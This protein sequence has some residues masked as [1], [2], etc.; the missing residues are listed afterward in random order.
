M[1][2]LR[3]STGA[4]LTAL[5]RDGLRAHTGGSGVRRCGGACWPWITARADLAC[6]WAMV[7]GLLGGGLDRILV[8]LMEH[9][10]TLA[11]CCL[12]VVLAFLLGR[13][14][15]MRRR[16]VVWCHPPVFPGGAQTRR[17]GEAELYVEAG[18]LRWGGAAWTC[19]LP[20][21]HVIHL[22]A[23][24]AH[25]Q[26]CEAV[27]V[28]GGLGFLGWGLPEIDSGN[29]APTCSGSHRAATGIWWTALYAGW[30][31]LCWT[32]LSFLGEGLEAWV[33]GGDG[34]QGRWMFSTRSRVALSACVH[35]AS[36]FVAIVHRF[37]GKSIGSNGSSLNSS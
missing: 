21:A 19:A 31:C 14:L 12:S 2:P 8:L 33:S 26:R 24:A 28:L 37:Y 29:G 13:G 10:Y 32:G 7:S 3:C 27:L 1:P 16:A 15:P 23:G 18:S 9:A 4:A 22:G 5:G 34:G 30:R 11:V 6:R 35:L 36:L 25:P 20:A 17:P